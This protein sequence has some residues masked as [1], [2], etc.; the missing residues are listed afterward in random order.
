MPAGAV[1][2]PPIHRIGSN[3]SGLTDPLKKKKEKRSRKRSRSRSRK[4]ML[5]PLNENFFIPQ[6]F[7][8]VSRCGVCGVCMSVGFTFQPV[9][10]YNGI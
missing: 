5:T 1:S 6:S 10:E 7:T 3:K 8:K 9:M 4:Q 2:P